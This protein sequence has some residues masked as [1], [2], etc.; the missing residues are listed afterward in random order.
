MTARDGDLL[1]RVEDLERQLRAA[2]EEVRDIT[3]IKDMGRG[4][5]WFVL[6]VG[7]VSATILVAI[8]AVIKGG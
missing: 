2:R 3:T 4:V 6:K 7:A 8:W 1:R 5:L